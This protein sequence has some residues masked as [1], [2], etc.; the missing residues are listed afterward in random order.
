[1]T[2]D[3]VIAILLLVL[4]AIFLFAHDGDGIVVGGF[5]IRG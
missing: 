2:V 4:A 3:C 1:M 5:C